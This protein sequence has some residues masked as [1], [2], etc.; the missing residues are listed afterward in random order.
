M[1]FDFQYPACWHGDCQ[2]AH[3]AEKAAFAQFVVELS[4]KFKPNGWLLSAAV[5]AYFRVVDG[6][7]D[8]PVLSKYLDWIGVMTYDF[9]GSWSKKTG[10]LAPLYNYPGNEQNNYVDFAIKYWIKKGANSRKIIMGAPT[11]GITYTLAN[12][13]NHGLNAAITGAGQA[14]QF[15]QSPGSLAYYEICEKVKKQGWTVVKNAQYG[16]YA[17]KGNQ[18]T[19]YDDIETM[20]TK[21]KYIRDSKLAGAMIWTLDFDDFNG[22]CGEGKYPLLTALNQA[23]R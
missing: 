11:Y 7:Y 2:P 8:V 9:H 1:I 23:L 14:G 18:W 4:Q 21:S 15:T 20:R 22:S 12:A 19:S 3:A 10:Q 17:F 13:Q 6:A 16:L 5:S